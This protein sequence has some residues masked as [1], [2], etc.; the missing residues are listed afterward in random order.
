MF[1]AP[2]SKSSLHLPR[3][4]ENPPNPLYNAR[5]HTNPSHQTPM[6]P[7]LPTLLRPARHED[8]PQILRVHRHAVRYSC[9]KSYTPEIMNAWLDLLEPESYLGP[10]DNPNKALWLIE[11]ENQI[12]GFFLLNYAEAQLEALYV[13]PVVHYSGLGT[14]LLKKAEALAIQADLSLLSLYASKNSIE[15]YRINGYESLGEAIMPLNE[16]IQAECLLMRKYLSQ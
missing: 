3:H 1:I 11:Y 14:A 5:P 10:I 15:F 2:A 12:Q 7:Q 16:H 6:M 4:I 13:H 8:C 9:L